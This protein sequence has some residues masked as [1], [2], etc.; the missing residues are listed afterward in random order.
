MPQ[1]R[2]QKGKK[3]K[4]RKRKGHRALTPWRGPHPREHIGPGG[5]QGPH[6]P[7]A[8]TLRVQSPTYEFG[9]DIFSHK[10]GSIVVT[11][12][13]RFSCKKIKFS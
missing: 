9:G 5:L 3:K 13:F 1:G 6:P 7:N 2:P 8:V 4:E 12:L 10:S 11:I